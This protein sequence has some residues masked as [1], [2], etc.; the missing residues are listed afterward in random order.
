MITIKPVRAPNKVWALA[1]CVLALAVCTKV[2]TYIMTSAS[3]IEFGTLKTLHLLGVILFLGNI[4][5]TAWWKVMADKT[6]SAAVVAFAQRQV[7]LTDFVF[8]AGGAAMLAASG[9]AMLSRLGWQLLQQPWMMWS[10]GLFAL[11]AVLWLAVLIPI[12]CKQSVMARAFEDT[13]P[14]A[15]W[16]LSRIWAAVGTIAI[17]LP[18]SI[19]VLMIFK[20]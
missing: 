5:V 10:V 12:Q 7:V 9:T 18:V 8:T 14:D 16:R 6:R 3:P 11:S 19:L 15:Y 17:L 4:S 20:I 2:A 1:T 13:V